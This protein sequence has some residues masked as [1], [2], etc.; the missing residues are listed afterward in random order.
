[1]NHTLSESEIVQELADRTCRRLTRRIIVTL[2]TMKDGLLSGHNSGLR[3]T[4]DEICAQLQFE[5]S[6]SWD[7]YEE[8]ISGLA[9][10]EIEGL[11][12]YEREAIWLQTSAGD[13]WL[14][15][16]QS[17]RP[18]YPV[19]ADDIVEYF[20]TEHLYKAAVNWSNGRIRDYLDR[21]NL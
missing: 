5:L 2:Q 17:L 4:W 7:A 1:M 19:L 20:I 18:A 3:N 14:W 11:Q 21:S 9:K 8:T 10:T 13:N 15:E 16:D 12:A 6:T